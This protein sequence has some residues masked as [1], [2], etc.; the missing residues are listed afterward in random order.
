[1]KKNFD[2]FKRSLHSYVSFAMLFILFILFTGMQ[3]A[4]AQGCVAIRGMGCSATNSGTTVSKSG[5]LFTSN[6]RYFQS[7]KHFRGSHEEKERVEKGTEVINDSY[8]MELGLSYGLSERVSVS[9]NLPLIYYDRSSLYEHYGNSL[10][11]NP[12]QKRFNTQASG[13]G[14]M[15]LGVL[16]TV[17]NPLA[18]SK[19][20]LSVGAGIKLPTGNENVT[21]DF[22][23][24]K[25]DGGDSTFVRP[26]DQSI[27]LGDGGVGFN[28]EIQSNLV[29]LNNLSLY[30]N[31]FYLFNPENTNNTLTRGTLAGA[32][33]LIA[34]HSVAD[35]FAVRLGANYMVN[36]QLNFGLGSRLEGIPSSDV[37][38]DSEG[39]R[40]P[41]Y[42][43]S[44]EPSASYQFGQNNL[45]LTVPF[46]LYRNRTKSVYDL[47]DPT[48]QRHG[49]AAFADYSLN[50][51][52]SHKFSLSKD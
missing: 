12:E 21:D 7:Y 35:Q 10:T 36:H 19:F 9:A 41:G 6:L 11:A 28:L 31:S 8:F 52:Y 4:N 23:R 49:D 30:F 5:L 26:V 38:G 43:I 29:L 14:D 34:Y 39:F 45:A 20:N 24:R 17:T 46:A 40:R 33:P 27:Q 48:G 37:F 50:L 42:V 25:S 2:L 44:V 15:R 1:M 22:H 13:I 18:H 32:D 47:A 51:T 3:V 16:Y